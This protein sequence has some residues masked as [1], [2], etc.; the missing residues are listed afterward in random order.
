MS[1]KSRGFGAEK[2][3]SPEE[4]QAKIN[5]VRKIIGPIADKY[6]V[7]CSDESISRYLRARNWHTKKASKMLVESV[8]WR[9]EY[10]P[11]KIVWEDVAREAE[12]GKLYRANFCDKLGRPVL[13]M[14][15]GFQVVK[16]FLEPKTYKKVR[17]A[18]SN[19]PQS[20]KI[21]EALFDINK[22]D[23]SFGGRSR[24][25]FDY[26]AFGQLMR[27]D[28]KKK[29]DLMNS[30]CSVPTDHLLVASQSSQSESLTSDHCS[31]DSDNELDEATSTLE[32]V[33]EKVPGLKLGYDDVPKSEAAMA[34]QVQ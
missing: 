34:K 9:L 28:D 17:F 26:E 27:A 10:K 16:P 2:S 12:T 13:I 7:L 21:M 33:D 23:S 8:K 30:G 6:P 3:L 19:D 25:G 15:P 22:L 20:Q 29:S 1:R 5:E 14:R 24:V 18:Y 11:E 4:Q 32:D 31:D